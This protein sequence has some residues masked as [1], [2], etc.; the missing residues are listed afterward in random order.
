M[1]SKRVSHPPSPLGGTRSYRSRESGR[2]SGVGSLSSDQASSG[3]KPDRR[4]TAH[5]YQDQHSNIYALQEA[6]DRATENVEHYKKKCRDL[7]NEVSNINKT[8]RETEAL[9]RAQCDRNEQLEQELS[10]IREQYKELQADYDDLRDK[11]SDLQQRYTTETRPVDS[12]MMSGAGDRPTRTKSK[13]GH[14]DK[15]MKDRMKDRLNRDGQKDDTSSKSSHQHSRRLSRAPSTSRKPYIEEMPP[16]VSS[17]SSRSHS[18]YKTTSQAPHI[19]S[20]A[21]V[22]RTSQPPVFFVASAPTHGTHVNVSPKGYT[23]ANFAVLGPNQ[24]AYVDRT[25]SGCETIS[26]LYENGRATLMFCS[27]GSSPR[28]MR[29]FCRG[30]VIEWDSPEFEPFLRKMKLQKVDAARAIIVLDIFQVQTSCGYGVPKVRRIVESE[31]DGPHA[32]GEKTCDDDDSEDGIRRERQD[33]GV[34]GFEERPTLQ[35]FNN[36]RQREGTAHHYQAEMNTCSID[37]LPGLRSARRD[38]GERLWLGDAKAHL[39]RMIAERHGMA[40]GFLTAVVFYF[41]LGLAGL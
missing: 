30:R 6:L 27:F 14:D 26:H 25:G 4:F 22:P 15:Q 16:P 32:A 17:K 13:H 34:A 5:D 37:G 35:F 21:S 8:N 1:S 31:A 23:N 19:V 12:P 40:F 10:L 20:Y 3:G 29:L 28:I 18:N 24:C 11:Y 39:N 36:K 38:V 9:F 7:N 2:D 33:I 41:L